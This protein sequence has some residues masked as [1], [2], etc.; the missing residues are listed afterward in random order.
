VNA[1][2]ALVVDDE[3]VVRMVLRRFFGRN[4]WAVLEAENGERALEILAGDTLPDVVICDLNL[5]GLSG[6]EFCQRVI[7]LVPLLA[8]RLVLTSGDPLSASAALEREHLDCPVLA[9]PFTI[10]DLDRILDTLSCAA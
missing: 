6:T 4:G 1:R 2:T 7:E 9:K 3:A 5:P 10:A 8:S